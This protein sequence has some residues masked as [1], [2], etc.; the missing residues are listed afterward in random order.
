MD[1][2]EDIRAYEAG[3]L[4]LDQII[5]L[6]QY[7]IDSGMLEHLGQNYAVIAESFVEKGFCHF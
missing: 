3:S 2:A 5:D 4:S 7:F 1:L 6:F